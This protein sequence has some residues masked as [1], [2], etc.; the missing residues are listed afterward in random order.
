M[1]YISSKDSIQC[2]NLRNKIVKKMNVQKIIGYGK[3]IICA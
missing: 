2:Y 3:G 1:M